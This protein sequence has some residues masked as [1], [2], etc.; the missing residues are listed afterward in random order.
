MSTYVTYTTYTDDQCTVEAVAPGGESATVTMDF[1]Q[2]CNEVPKASVSE[3]V[4][5]PDRIVYTNHPNSDDCSAAPH[6]N[7]IVI[8]VCTEFPGP[9]P[10]WKFIE[11]DTYSCASF[12]NFTGIPDGCDGANSAGGGMSGL[13]MGQMIQHLGIVVLLLMSL[14]CFACCGYKCYKRRQRRAREALLD[15]GDM[16]MNTGA[17]A[18]LANV[19]PVSHEVPVASIV[20]SDQVVIAQEAP[21]A[22]L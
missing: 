9:V 18:K 15:G 2:T 8:G 19:E 6:C 1:T 14:C 12:E 5:Y 16:T 17:Y 10:S 22:E 4:C 3:L 11:P 20:Q 21:A 7:E 13:P